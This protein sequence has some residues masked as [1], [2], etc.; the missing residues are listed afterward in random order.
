MSELPEDLAY[1]VIR[2]VDVYYSQLVTLDILFK[3]Q[4]F[5][6]R[7]FLEDYNTPFSPIVRTATNWNTVTDEWMVEK[8]QE[9]LLQYKENH[10]KH[11]VLSHW[12]I[13]YISD[14]NK[15]TL[16]K[17]AN[18]TSAGLAPELNSTQVIFGEHYVS[19]I[20]GTAGSLDAFATVTDKETWVGFQLTKIQESN[21]YI[22]PA[23]Y[24]WRFD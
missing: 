11:L 9:A 16:P 23:V 10:Q 8:N 18:Y 19:G 12:G 15:P 2:R 6:H 20:G 17:L 14:N 21:F 13:F 4:A 1:R 3:D 24:M 7:Q 5:I 22:L